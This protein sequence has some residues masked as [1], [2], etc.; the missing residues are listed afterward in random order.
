MCN[1]A[2]RLLMHCSEI[3]FVCIAI[4]GPHGCEEVLYPW[5]FLALIWT[6]VA[7]VMYDMFLYKKNYF[8]KL[9]KMPMMSE[10]QMRFNKELFVK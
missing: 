8:V 5:P 3:A 7:H 6:I 4:W 9:D 1:T 2:F 10:N